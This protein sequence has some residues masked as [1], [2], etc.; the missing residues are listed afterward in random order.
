MASAAV[1]TRP[2][3]LKSNTD[4]YFGKPRHEMDDMEKE[5]EDGLRTWWL[6]VSR[7]SIGCLIS[8]LDDI[9]QGVNRLK[10]LAL[11][12]NEELESQKPLTDRLQGK[13]EALND[14]VNKKNKDMKTIL[15]R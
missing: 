15:L 6:K 13:I 14:G 8:L 5:T 9:H 3:D 11:Q 7:I 2:T 12:M 10:L 1:T 4:T